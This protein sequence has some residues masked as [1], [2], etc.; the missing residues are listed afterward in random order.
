MKDIVTEKTNKVDRAPIVM[1]DRGDCHFVEKARHIQRAGGKVALVVNNDD[2]PVEHIIMADDGTGGDIMIPL[3][4]ISKKD[5]QILEDHYKNNK[6]NPDELRR[7]ILDVD[8]QIEHNSNT[9][10]VEVF[11]NSESEEVYKLVD[12]LSKFPELLEYLN[13]I[14][15]YLTFQR[16]DFD[17]SIEP[18]KR[19]A[20]ENCLG[21]G[22][23]CAR[24]FYS[25]EKLDEK[26]VLKENLLQKCIWQYTSD[27]NI[28]G[29]YFE[30]L[31]RFYYGCYKS[32]DQGESRFTIECGKATMDKVGLPESK[33]DKCFAESFITNEEL[34]PIEFK[35]MEAVLENKIFNEDIAKKSKM[36]AK[37]L[38]S[39]FINGKQFWGSYEKK[40]VLEAICSG[41][42][43]KLKSAIKKEALKPIE[44]KKMEAVLENKIFNEDIAKKSKMHA[45]LL[46]S[47][48]INGKQFWGSYEKKAVLEAICS[49]LQKKPEIC[50]KEGGFVKTST[51]GKTFWKFFLIVLGIV[52][53][54]SLIIFILCRK[55]MAKSVVDKLSESDID[56]KVNTVVTSYLALKDKS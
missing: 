7:L 42:Q 56:L 40:A 39:A 29:Q 25:T 43:K 11:M 34:K 2:V 12:E 38:P 55:Y 15:Y 6:N 50:Y 44:F 37:L 8:F 45:K 33:I 23:Y 10:K 32:T 20:D 49:G 1:V 3:V 13:F 46:P 48:F 53:G 30:Y 9:V 17:N 21:G 47:A 28:T 5:G 31:V 4:L 52:L 41:L 24:P 54:I 19:V 27:R 14:P 16:Y 36:H 22:K 18:E 26:S 51:T 35:R